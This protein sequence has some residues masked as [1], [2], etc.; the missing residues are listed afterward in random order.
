M[1]PRW[2]VT[3]IAAASLSLAACGQGGTPAATPTPVPVDQ[4][5]AEVTLAG[6]VQTDLA[7]PWAVAFTPDGGALITE[8]DTGLVRYRSG[9][10]EITDLGVVPEVVAEGEGGLLG[11]TLDPRN[12]DIMFV[13]ITAASDNRILRMPWS[14]VGLGDA[15]VILDGIE[16]ATFHNGGRI[17]IGPDGH[18]YVGTGDAGEPDIAQDPTRLA[19]KVLRVTTDGEVPPGNP[20]SDSPVWTLGHRNVQGLA[21]DAQGQLW[22]SEFGTSIA[23]ELNVL[24]AGGNYGWP[25]HEGAAQAPG[26]IDPVAQWSPTSL[27][28]PSGIAI[29][30]DASPAVYVASLR[31][32]VLWQVPIQDGRAGEP[33]AVELGDLGRLR[34]VDVTPQGSL[35]LTTNNT[36]GRGEPRPTDD[37]IV[38]LKLTNS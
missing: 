9:Q 34:T 32:E 27:A 1:K 19:G 28:S 20:I 16:K 24:T 18:L 26:F 21:F 25:I 15:T 3:L 36:D 37:R 8:R 29:T 17:I 5:P 38:E 33:R 13:Y 14:T 12:P 35:W 10:G 4:P 23:D 7:A 22:A 2:V 30:T 31:G 6:V 11:I